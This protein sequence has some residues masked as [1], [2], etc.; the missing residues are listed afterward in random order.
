[1]P[2]GEGGDA[3]NEYRNRYAKT[4]THAYILSRAEPGRN[5]A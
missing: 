2:A 5:V 1:V 4:A 3:G